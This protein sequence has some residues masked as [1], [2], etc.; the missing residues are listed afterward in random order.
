MWW[1][2]GAQV[3]QNMGPRSGHLFSVTAPYSLLDK[4]MTQ[5]SQQR[6]PCLLALHSMIVS[7][8]TPFPCKC[9]TLSMQT[10]PWRFHSLVLLALPVVHCACYLILVPCFVK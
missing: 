7:L 2:F 3:F 8:N 9:I 1:R 4:S 6:S 5:C 10:R